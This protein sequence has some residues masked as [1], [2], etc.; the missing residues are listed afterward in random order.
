MICGLMK[1]I[2][3]VRCDGAILLREQ[4]AE[5][6]DRIDSRNAVTGAI[7]SLTDQSCHS[8]VCPLATAIEL[9]TRRCDTVGV[10][11]VAFAL[12]ATALISCS[13]FNRTLPLALIRGATRRMTPVLR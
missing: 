5:A 13:M 11:V 7:L 2:S 10:S 12:S 3:S 8:T 9:A 6:G 4:I 1:I